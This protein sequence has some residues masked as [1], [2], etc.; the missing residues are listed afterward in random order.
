MGPV[1]LVP[2]PETTNSTTRGAIVQEQ[3]NVRAVLSQYE[4]AYTDLD[5]DAAARIYPKLDKKALARAF[6]TLNAQQILLQDCRIQVRDTTARAAC[7]GS[8]MWT[9]KVGGGSHQ[10]E[11]EWQ[12]EL[13]RTADNWRIDGVKIR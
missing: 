11:R 13:L 4:A 7:T 6:G 3:E 12:F 1:P 10:Q 5:A 8:A 2:F 9:P